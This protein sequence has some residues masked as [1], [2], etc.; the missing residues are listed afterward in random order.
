MS[1]REIA[2]ELIN[3][4]PDGVSLYE[5]ARQIEFAAAVREGLADAE[6]G[7]VVPLDEV[8]RELE[9]WISK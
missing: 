5:I 1:N 7:D 6:K 9:E 2:A 8:E 4:M 3:R